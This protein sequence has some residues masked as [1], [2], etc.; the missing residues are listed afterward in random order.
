MP[1]RRSVELSRRQ[2]ARLEEAAKIYVP[3]QRDLLQGQLAR[4]AKLA[5]ED[6]AT[7]QAIWQSV[8]ELHGDKDWAQD[9]VRQARAALDEK[10][11]QQ[12]S[13]AGT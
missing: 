10:S 3:I 7:A 9:L 6:P 13:T 2:M 11:K 4:A 1:A 5:D 12:A 8:I